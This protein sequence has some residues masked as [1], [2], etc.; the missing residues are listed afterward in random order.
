MCVCHV[1][2][3]RQTYFCHLAPLKKLPVRGRVMM[4]IVSAVAV[5]QTPSTGSW[6]DEK[7]AHFLKVRACMRTLSAMTR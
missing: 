6:E 5:A 3:R 7:G 4:N 1:A 2:W